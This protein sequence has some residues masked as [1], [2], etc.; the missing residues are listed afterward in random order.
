MSAGSIGRRYA[1]AMLSV[2]TDQKRLDQTVEEL[3]TLASM[4]ESSAELR[5]VLQNPVYPAS[6]RAGVLASLASRLQLWPPTAQLLSLLD[7]RRRLVLLPDIARAIREMADEQERRL[8]AHV[9][10]AA[11]L[12]DVYFTQLKTTLERATGYSVL[13]RSDVDAAL[14]GGVVTRIGDQV[15]D[16]SLRTRLDE[17]RD[18][19]LAEQ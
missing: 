10:S 18:R 8:R 6:I 3:Q 19:L 14:L 4:W 16:G 15:F 17:M 9:T 12:P 13:M 1:R 5:N 11:P 2:A 7:E